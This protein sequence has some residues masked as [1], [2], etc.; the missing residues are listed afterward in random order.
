MPAQAEILDYLRR[1]GDMGFKWNWPCIDFEGGWFNYFINEQDNELCIGQA[2]GDHKQIARQA[3]ALASR[4]KCARII[5]ATKRNGKA[6]ERLTGA[7]VFATV[8]E[9]PLEA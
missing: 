6:F 8:L 7:K 3:R 4:L 1:S 9:L 2:Y 5:F